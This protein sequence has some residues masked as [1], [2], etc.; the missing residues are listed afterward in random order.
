MNRCILLLLG[1]LLLVQGLHIHKKQPKLRTTSIFIRL[2]GK[3]ASFLASER[4]N[5]KKVK[6]MSDKLEVLTFVINDFLPTSH[7]I[8]GASYLERR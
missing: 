3:F 1:A 2:F 7:Q 6:T 4:F 5:V 8:M